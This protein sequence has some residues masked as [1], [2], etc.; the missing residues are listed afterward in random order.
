MVKFTRDSHYYHIIVSKLAIILSTMNENEHGV[1]NGSGSEVPMN[2]P[3]SDIHVSS[4]ESYQQSL[5][6]GFAGESGN[7]LF[8]YC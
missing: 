3:F 6:S 2:N 5:S 8:G 7:F 1:I 4:S